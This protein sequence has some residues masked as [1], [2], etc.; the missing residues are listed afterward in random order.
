MS[1]GLLF[2]VFLSE[3]NFVKYGRFFYRLRAFW[4]WTPVW[5]LRHLSPAVKG[6]LFRVSIMSAL[7][8][9][10]QYWRLPVHLLNKLR[11]CCRSMLLRLARLG[12]LSKRVPRDPDVTDLFKLFFIDPLEGLLGR[13]RLRWVCHLLRDHWRA[14][15]VA[16]IALAGRV[17]AYMPPARDSAIAS[18]HQDDPN[19]SHHTKVQDFASLYHHDLTSYTVEETGSVESIQQR[20]LAPGQGDGYAC[21]RGRCET[22]CR[23][24]IISA[25]Q[26]CIRCPA[27]LPV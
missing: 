16:S 24:P 18:A 15:S 23:Q 4:L 13:R 1:D 20:Q 12:G 27:C 3:G 7:L 21:D 10:S 14:P 26:A 19:P 25:T 11:T 9:G 5:N 2:R 6:Q 22:I 8:Y 17:T